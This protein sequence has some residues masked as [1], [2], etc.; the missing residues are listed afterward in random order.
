MKL[1]KFAA[2]VIGLLV[3]AQSLALTPPLHS[4]DAFKVITIDGEDMPSALDLSIDDL[5][6]AAMVDGV[7]EPIPY[8]IDQY[9]VGG[10]VYFEGW[11]VPLAGSPDVLDPTDKL[12]FLFKDAGEKYDGK[13]PYDGTLI[14]E[15]LTLDRDGH[16]RYV[17]LVKDSRYTYRLWPSRSR[18][19]ISEP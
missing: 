12:L 1:S 2:M 5:S 6:L 9:N 19:S 8:Q 13:V 7:M 18:V 15:I 14:A 3:S 11:D 17:Y 16:K 4:I 10:A